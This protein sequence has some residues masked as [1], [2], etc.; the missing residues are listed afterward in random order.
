MDGKEKYITRP[1]KALVLIGKNVMLLKDRGTA[2]ELEKE[3][4]QG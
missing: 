4:I 3:L 1:E 2:R